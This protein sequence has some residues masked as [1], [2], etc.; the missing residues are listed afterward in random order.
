M[1]DSRYEQ[2]KTL[3]GE[4][5]LAEASAV[6]TSLLA[7][8]PGD[9]GALYA[10][11]VCQLDLGERARARETLRRVIAAHPGHYGAEYQLG[12]LLQDQGDLAGAAARYRNVLAVNDYADTEARLRQCERAGA[13]PPVRKMIEQS[14]VAERGNPGM[15]LR[16]RARHIL[17]FGSVATLLS[18]VFFARPFFA[19][20]DPEAT[21]PLAQL[22]MLA[23]LLL[24]MN[25]ALSPIT[26]YIRTRAYTTQLYDYGMDVSTGVFRR[27]RQFVWYYQITE[28]PTYV[29]DAREYLTHTASLLISYN[30][31]ATTTVRMKLRGI[32]SPREV[33]QMRSYLQSRIPAER[34]PIRGPWT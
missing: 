12:R 15:T 21:Y 19:F 27:S 13:V 10:L 2:A 28:P 11:A 4:G 16:L 25:I 23:A 32:G 5:R 26:V 8:R 30:N 18:M 22:L 7:E 1:A 14:Y 3:R 29:R 34:L 20:V 9:V 6:L 33:E 17:P 24:L 31:T